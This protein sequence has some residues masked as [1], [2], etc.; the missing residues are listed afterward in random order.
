MTKTFK[1]VLMDKKAIIY[2]KWD[3]RIITSLSLKEVW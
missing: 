2:D 3:Y 1:A